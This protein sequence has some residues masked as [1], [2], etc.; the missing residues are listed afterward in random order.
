M[1]ETM[2]RTMSQTGT[3]RGSSCPLEHPLSASRCDSQSVC[4]V[5]HSTS[6]A[7]TQCTGDYIRDICMCCSGLG[8]CSP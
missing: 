1:R 7:A 6:A 2:M 4:T 5:K 8:V 3:A